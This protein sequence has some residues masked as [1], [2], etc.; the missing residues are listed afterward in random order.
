MYS[1]A[2]NNSL[3]TILAPQTH[4]RTHQMN[5]T[6]MVFEASSP[7]GK[8]ELKTRFCLGPVHLVWSSSCSHRAPARA[9]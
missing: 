2:L 7:D 1:K 5:Q 8:D 4:I 6:K 3:L 9:S